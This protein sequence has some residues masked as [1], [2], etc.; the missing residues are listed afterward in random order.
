MPTPV[1]GSEAPHASRP[2]PV[3]GPLAGTHAGLLSSAALRGPLLFAQWN[4]ERRRRAL[5]QRYGEEAGGLLDDPEASLEFLFPD[6]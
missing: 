3:D 6:D 2:A 1:D 5:Q 4:R